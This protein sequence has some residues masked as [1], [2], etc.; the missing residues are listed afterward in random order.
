VKNIYIAFSIISPRLDITANK[1]GNGIETKENVSIVSKN[2]KA[3]STNVGKNSVNLD[4]VDIDKI[5]FGDISYSLY[6]KK[7]NYYISNSFND[8]D[9]VLYSGNNFIPRFSIFNTYS[10]F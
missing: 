2:Q 7:G 8:S 1:V 5:Y 9:Y 6:N 4:K 3:T 10:F